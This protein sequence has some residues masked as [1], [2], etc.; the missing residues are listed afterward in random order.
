MPASRSFTQ[1]ARRRVT[2]A[3][4]LLAKVTGQDLTERRRRHVP[5]RPQG[6]KRPGDLDSR[7]GRRHGHKTTARSFDGFK[8]H[9]AVDPDSEIITRNGRD[10]GQAAT[11]VSPAN[12]IADLLVD[13]DTSSRDTAEHEGAGGGRCRHRGTRRRHTVYGDNAYGTGKLQ[14]L[15]DQAGITSRCKTQQVTAPDGLFSKDRFAIDLDKGTVTCPAG[16]DGTN[17]RS[18][19]A[20]F[21]GACT[22]CPLRRSALL[23]KVVAP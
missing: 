22:D 17:P 13:D 4:E 7:P 12:L 14:A 3:A 11:P 18:P 23:L 15:L 19:H 6:R 2:K 21:G 16:V 5:H 9:V 1:T 10:A 20:Y 8:G